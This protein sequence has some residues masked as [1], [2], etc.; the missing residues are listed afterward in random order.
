MT[1]WRITQADLPGR[2]KLN[3][4]GLKL[5]RQG[6][7]SQVEAKLMGLA[8]KDCHAAWLLG[9]ASYYLGHTELRDVA[10]KEA[11]HCSRVYREEVEIF[12][13]EREDLARLAVELY[14]GDVGGWFWLAKIS[15]PKD[16]ENAAR[17]IWKGLGLS[18]YNDW[19][20]RML[21][22]ALAQLKP[23]RAF[24]L[25]DEFGVK[26]IGEQ[27]IL[28]R[29]QSIFL[30]A[31]I[32]SKE[33]PDKAIELY[34]EGLR[35]NPADGVRWKELAELLRKDYPEEALNAYIKSC[36]LGDPGFH[37][38]YNAGLIY[39]EMGNYQEAIKFYRLSKWQVSQER[40]PELEI[41]SGTPQP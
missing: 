33:A 17:Y 2:L 1:A 21:G 7:E 30:F 18:P 15:L 25:Y 36:R 28:N 11:L 20:W 37:G 14:P 3:F 23:D 4:V 19:G 13:P 39:E 16:P 40:V 38:C 27:N 32:L 29:D 24:E 9:M 31:R 5:L 10:W 6:E 22:D 34:R 41:K 8:S 35:Y 12:A 26:D